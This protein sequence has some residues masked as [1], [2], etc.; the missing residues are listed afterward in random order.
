MKWR[1]AWRELWHHPLM[2]LLIFV[3]N[4]VVFAVTVSMI[5]TIVSRYNTYREISDLVS[6]NGAVYTLESYQD[7]YKNKE[8]EWHYSCAYTREEVE[9]GLTDAKVQGCYNWGV[10]IDGDVQSCS[11]TAYDDALWK[12]HRPAI[13]AGRW[14]SDRDK[15]TEE[16]EVVIAQKGGKDGRY[17]VGDTLSAEKE[18]RDW[19]NEGDDTKIS[20]K[21]IGIIE[22]GA[23]ILGS[24]LDERNSKEDYRTLFWNY[25]DYYN[26]GL[27]LFGIQSDLLRCKHQHAG[28]WTEKMLG[29]CFFS[30]ETE[31]PEVI[32]SN[33]VKVMKNAT[34]TDTRDYA[35]IRRE[36]K[37]YIWE[38][39]R[40]I[41]PIL[42]TLCIMTVLSTV[43]NMAIMVQKS[44][45]NY[46][47]YYI[48]GLSWK[49]CISIHIF[50]MILLEG[51]SFLLMMAGLFLLKLGGALKYTVISPGL[52]QMAGCLLLCL[53]FTLFGIG[54]VR[55]ETPWSECKGNINERGRMMI[56]IKNLNKAYNLGEENGCEVLKGINLTIPDGEMTAIMGASGAG[57]ST[58]LHILSCIDQYDN[59]EYLLDGELIGRMGDARMAEIRNEKMGIVMQDFALIEDFTA[60]ENVMMPLDFSANKRRKK[61]K[62]NMALE[63][64][65]AVSM[66]EY[67]GKPVCKL[68][69]G[70]KQR[71]AIARGLVN[72][73]EILFADEPT[74]ALDSVTSGEIMKL[75]RTLNE[76]GT[77]MVIVTHDRLVAESCDRII[78][79][80]D[81]RVQDIA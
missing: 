61:E 28:A 48:N 4:V 44:L 68:S 67:A 35:L 56:E 70:Q 33:Q 64:L 81:G 3:Q 49:K 52:W 22:N 41:L 39:V 32:S 5:S 58:L 42:I 38:Q 15:Q 69:G 27:Y 31:D 12:C 2:M 7:Y 80:V 8:G 25:Y 30:W 21:V 34:A 77:T 18:L 10:G 19:V 78:K 47:V 20:F 11:L 14:F 60:L 29:E 59:G 53:L 65:E 36:S 62:R 45:R 13:A 76:K 71:V 17:Q 6:G 50:S 1:Y 40:M 66:K 51:G 75:L 23:S 57:K 73:P 37:K 9:S 74:G 43:C 24:K 26:D 72:R 16:L 79:I 54:V 63:A 55:R 46:A